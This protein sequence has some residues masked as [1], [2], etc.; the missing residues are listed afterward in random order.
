MVESMLQQSWCLQ[1]LM[2]LKG[3]SAPRILAFIY[4]PE[5][6]GKL[7]LMTVKE[8]LR[9]RKLYVIIIADDSLFFWI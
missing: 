9:D 8:V 4:G 6:Q 3:D 2:I 1:Y 7:N 5:Q